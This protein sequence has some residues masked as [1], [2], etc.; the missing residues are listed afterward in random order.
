M[1]S[2]KLCVVYIKPNKKYGYWKTCSIK[3]SEIASIRK[4]QEVRLYKGGVIENIDGVDF[5]TDCQVREPIQAFS[6][7]AGQYPMDMASGFEIDY[8]KMF[9]LLILSPMNRIVEAMGYNPVDIGMNYVEGL[10]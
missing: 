3:V 8:D 2:D 4:K 9:D 10:W 1:D 5:Y 7:P 6:Y